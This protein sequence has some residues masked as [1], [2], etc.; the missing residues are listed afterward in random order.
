MNYV[1]E[2]IQASRDSNV[3]EDDKQAILNSLRN[4]A[5]NGDVS[6]RAALDS[7]SSPSL[8]GDLRSLSFAAVFD[9]CCKAGWSEKEFEFWKQWRTVILADVD[10]LAGLDST[11]EEIAARRSDPARI[12]T[13][14][15]Y[16][17]CKSRGMTLPECHVFL[18]KLGV[19]S[20]YN[21]DLIV[22]N[23]ASC[24]REGKTIPNY[25]WFLLKLVWDAEHLPEYDWPSR[26]LLQSTLDKFLPIAELTVLL[27]KEVAALE[28][29][30]LTTG[31]HHNERVSE[32]KNRPRVR[33]LASWF[34]SRPDTKVYL[35]DSVYDL[36]WQMTKPA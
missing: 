17:Y 4:L 36:F 16:R 11:A 22:Y 29:E 31:I 15:L 18:D 12:D 7:N 34:T 19:G 8:H 32:I 33:E 6:A 26:E 3:K 20:T 14:L 25:R 1:T 2:L 28:H 23:A 13:A 30:L 21:Y 35:P 27:F 5:D 9:S 24:D 10:I